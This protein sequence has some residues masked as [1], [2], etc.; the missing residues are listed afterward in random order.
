MRSNK[1]NLQR[2]NRSGRSCKPSRAVLAILLAGAAAVSAADPNLP[3]AATQPA[4][5]IRATSAALNGM[6]VPGSSAAVAWFEWGTTSK[7]GNTAGV[8]NL[9]SGGGVVPVRSVLTGLDTHHVYHFRLVASNALGV[10]YGAH[11]QFTTGSQ[12][13]VWGNSSSGQRA[14]PAD[15]TNAVAIGGGGYHCAALKNDGTI[16]AWGGNSHSQTNVPADLT[17][18][19]AL[20]VG[21][22][23]ALALLPD[24]TVRAWGGG[25]IVGPPSTLNGGQSI[26]PAGLSNVVQIAA[27]TEHCVA[28]KADGTV[29]A[30]GSA[31]IYYGFWSDLGQSLVPVDL[32]NVVQIACGDFYN[33]ALKADGTV[34]FWGYSFYG[35]NSMPPGLADVGGIAAGWYDSMALR[36]DRTLAGWGYDGYGEADV[37]PGLDNVADMAGGGFYSLAIK[38]DGTGTGWGRDDQGQVSGIYGFTNLV[39]IAAGF[40]FSLALQSAAPIETPPVSLSLGTISDQLQLTWSGGVLQWADSPEGPY[41]DMADAT[42]PLTFTPAADRQFYRVRVQP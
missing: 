18:V 31:W 12:V 21:Q 33:L 16:A 13:V 19:V 1:D 4:N 3:Q 11:R 38:A 7:Y 8:T 35:E 24:G 39:A 40:D 26:V 25:Q 2:R 22:V 27:G 29:A 15:L 14:V 6:V 20:A 23:N 5:A 28:L 34:V 32:T 37:P 41:T 42:S 30:W 36:P 9:P 17:N 10:V